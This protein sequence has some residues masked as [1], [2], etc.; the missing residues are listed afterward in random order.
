MEYRF[1]GRTRLEAAGTEGWSEQWIR[2]YRG[3][4]RPPLTG[5][6]ETPCDTGR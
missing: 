1:L 3:G 4:P 5:E 2:V 6:K